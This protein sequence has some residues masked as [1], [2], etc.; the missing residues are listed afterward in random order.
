MTVGDFNVLYCA[1]KL[2]VDVI[3]GSDGQ[4]GPKNGP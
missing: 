3:P 1:R 2:G 4:C